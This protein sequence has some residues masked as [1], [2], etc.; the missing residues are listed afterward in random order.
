MQ[1]RGGRGEGIFHRR[2]PRMYVDKER[3]DQI[4]CSNL[5]NARSK[6]LTLLRTAVEVSVRV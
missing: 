3:A 6:M 1:G 4:V 2:V 5:T